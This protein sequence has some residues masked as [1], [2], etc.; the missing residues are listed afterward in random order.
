[1]A[2]IVVRDKSG[3]HDHVVENTS[4]IGRHPRSTICLHDALVSK[5]HAIIHRVAGEYL[6]EDLGSANG[7]FLDGVRITRHKLQDG[8]ELTLGKVTLEFHADSEDEQMASLVDISKIS[9]ISQVRDRIEVEKVEQFLPERQVS[10]LGLLRTDYEKLRLGH[11]LLQN[12]GLDNSIASVLE[13][14]SNELLRIFHA[15]R[16]V[17]LLLNPSTGELIPK[18]VRTIDGAEDHTSVSAS[19]LHEVQETRAALLLS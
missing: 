6:Y 4:S 2:R 5:R 18:V 13:K 1:M 16:C 17:I 15:G 11:E 3:E 7:S 8:D 12:I 9:D 19:V 10:D 14:V